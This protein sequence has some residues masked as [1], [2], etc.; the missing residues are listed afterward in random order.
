MEAI[1]VAELGT[2]GDGFTIHA[3][4]I[5]GVWRYWFCHDS[6]G[7][8]DEFGAA[9]WSSR[10]SQEMDDLESLLRSLTFGV[11]M[12]FR[13]YPVSIHPEFRPWFRKVYNERY[14]RLTEDQ[15]SQHSTNRHQRWVS[16]LGSDV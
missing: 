10:K 4:Q 6:M 7:H 8:V 11:E 2:E 12:W 13:F 5:D 3:R 14:N 16:L 1:V 9:E 15:R